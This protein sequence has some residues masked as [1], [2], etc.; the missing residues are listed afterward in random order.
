MSTFERDPSSRTLVLC[1]DGTGNLFSSTVRVVIPTLNR[2]SNMLF[3][4]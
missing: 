3:H 2:K 1:F 4:I